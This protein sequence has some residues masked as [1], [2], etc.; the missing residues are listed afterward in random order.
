[1]IIKK[2]ISSLKHRIQWKRQASKLATDNFLNQKECLSISPYERALIVSTHADDE[3]IGVFKFLNTADSDVLYMQKYGSNV[4]QENKDIRDNELLTMSVKLGFRLINFDS[5]DSSFMKRISIIFIPCIFDWHDEHIE[6]IQT[7]IDIIDPNT[8]IYFYQ[9]TVLL[10]SELITHYSLFSIREW[11]YKW[12][13]IKIAY[14]SQKNLP[15]YRFACAERS[16][17]KKRVG[18]ETF[19]LVTLRDVKKM[20]QFRSNN[21]ALFHNLKNHLNNLLELQKNS[22]SLYSKYKNTK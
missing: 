17:T 21:V 6:S 11:R 19:S 2:L 1:M 8:K 7:I 18:V 3:S 15:W 16:R 5:F 22:N 12:K 20:I 10:P 4:C 14:A 13:E 9:E